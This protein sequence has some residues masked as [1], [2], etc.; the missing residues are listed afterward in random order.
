MSTR[1][2]ARK[3]ERRKKAAQRRALYQSHAAAGR[4]K[5]S[6]RF[7]RTQR[8]NRKLNPVPHAANNCGNVG[9]QR[10][11]EIARAVATRPF[12]RRHR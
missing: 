12:A 8:L 1:H 5:Q 11:S 9:C 6:Q 10:C 2:E 3:L 7:R 4:T